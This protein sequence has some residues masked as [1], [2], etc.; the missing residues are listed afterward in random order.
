MRLFVDVLQVYLII[1]PFLLWKYV[2]MNYTVKPHTYFDE[3]ILLCM[4]NLVTS[5]T[6]IFFFNYY[7]YVEDRDFFVSLEWTVFLVY[8]LLFTVTQ[9]YYRMPV[10][11]DPIVHAE[12]RILIK[13]NGFSLFMLGFVT[14]YHTL[15]EHQF[16]FYHF[17]G[18]MK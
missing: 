10:D 6:V 17:N 1:V 13:I 15:Y 3:S 14:I 8:A 11:L 2:R 12:R 9:S 5:I 7:F 18:V 4:S 16:P